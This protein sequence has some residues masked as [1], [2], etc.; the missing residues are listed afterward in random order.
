M[1]PEIIAQRWLLFF[2]ALLLDN[3]HTRMSVCVCVC[4]RA[5]NKLAIFII[6][7]RERYVLLCWHLPPDAALYL[8]LILFSP[9]YRLII[10]LAA[11]IYEAWLVMCWWVLCCNKHRKGRR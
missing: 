3:Y 10:N 11:L 2:P 1:L 6:I 5:I 7:T 9:R 8:T 4:L